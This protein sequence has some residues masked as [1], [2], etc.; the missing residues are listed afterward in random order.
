MRK[1]VLSWILTLVIT[2]LFIQVAY[3]Q[4]DVKLDVKDANGLNLDGKSVS[5]GT[6]VY[7]Y[8]SYEDLNGN[9]PAAALM[10]VLFDDGGQ[11]QETI[12]F[13]NK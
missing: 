7:L 2:T 6:L 8:G 12:I 5:P 4:I 10:V 1:Q 13:D 9:S 3:A 11:T